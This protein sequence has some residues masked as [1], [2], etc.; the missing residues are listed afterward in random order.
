M[1][2][3]YWEQDGRWQSTT[4][5]N[6]IDDK[7]IRKFTVENVYRDPSTLNIVTDGGVLNNDSKII[8]LDVSWNYKGSTSSKQ[9]SFYI[10]NLYE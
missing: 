6:L 7:F 9:L 5:L 2:H 8:N 1:V 10:F 4:T 3:S